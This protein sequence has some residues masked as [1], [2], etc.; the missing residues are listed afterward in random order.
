MSRQGE[1][2]VCPK[3]LQ[4]FQT[5]VVFMLFLFSV[6]LPVFGTLYCM[7]APRSHHKAGHAFSHGRHSM[8]WGTRKLNRFGQ[9]GSPSLHCSRATLG[10]LLLTPSLWVV[11]V[12]SVYA[13]KSYNHASICGLSSHIQLSDPASTEAPL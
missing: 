1:V 2:C 7:W 12:K 13:L 9:L 11:Q 4:N 3:K 10:V 5:V 8:V 6:C